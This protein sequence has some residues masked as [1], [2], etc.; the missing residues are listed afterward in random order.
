MS[1]VTV[2]ANID[3]FLRAGT[4]AAAR[5][6][7]GASGYTSV[8][9]PALLDAISA[10]TLTAGT[11]Y[12]IADYAT[13]YIRPAYIGGVWTTEPAASASEPLLVMATS[14]NTLS[15][16]AFSAA[17][18]QD[19]IEYDVHAVS[20]GVI[21]GRTGYILRRT[22]TKAS[23]SLPYDYRTMKW[24]RYQSADS[25]GLYTAGHEGGPTPNSSAAL[26]FTFT[27]TLGADCADNTAA[28]VRFEQASNPAP[29]NN[30]IAGNVSDVDVG[31]GFYG[32]TIGDSFSFNTIGANFSS[33]TIGANFSSNTIGASFSGNTIG[34]DFSNNAIGD[35]FSF[36]TIGD[37][38]YLNTI[39]D[40]FSFNTIGDSFSFNTIG[41]SFSSNTIGDGFSNNNIGYGFSSNTIGDGLY[42]NTIGYG[43]SSNTIGYGFSSNTIGYG[44]SSNTIGYG[45]SSNTI[46]DGFIG[47]T[48]GDGF[49]G[50]TIGDNFFTNTI[51]TGFTNNSVGAKFGWLVQGGENAGDVRND[52]PGYEL[53][54]Y[55]PGVNFIGAGATLIYNTYPKTI[56]A[57][58]TGLFHLFYLDGT[59][60]AYASPVA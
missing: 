44:F 55:P 21:T 42:S 29:S 12:L 58:S 6:L 3:T 25:S 43:F 15:P 41:D 16:I 1:D 49:I 24:N 33:N 9:H 54:G 60:V 46:G 20:E 32:N 10:S 53:L 4:F 59:T 57:D 26:F 56:L 37:S 36:N 38:L 31:T 45:F 19:V 51:G 11:W 47:N 30:V 23:V 34:S 48:I 5:A 18:P 8:T 28:V 7:L 13:Q 52:Y 2:S 22:D 17:Y 27:T 14:A 39:G 35:S 50:N 40:S